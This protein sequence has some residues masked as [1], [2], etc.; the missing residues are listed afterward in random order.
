MPKR[1]VKKEKKKEKIGSNLLCKIIFLEN[2][3]NFH[4]AAIVT[5]TMNSVIWVEK[6]N[7]Q[8]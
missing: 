2:I 1:F 6:K 7:A 4:L 3:K 5:I 8:E